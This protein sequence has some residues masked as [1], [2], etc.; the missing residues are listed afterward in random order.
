MLRLW[1]VTMMIVI[2]SMKDGHYRLSL[3]TESSEFNV[4]ADEEDESIE[5]M[6]S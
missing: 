5:E 4:S 1:P 3:L 6:K 2:L